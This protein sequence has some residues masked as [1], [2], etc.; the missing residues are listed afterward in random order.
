MATLRLIEDKDWMGR[1]LKVK[2][3]M[4]VEYPIDWGGRVA[5]RGDVWVPKYRMSFANGSI[6]E[7]IPQGGDMIRSK[8]P[9]LVR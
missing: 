3:E 8:T 2:R 7:G 6:I 1:N 5:M 9:S 4:E